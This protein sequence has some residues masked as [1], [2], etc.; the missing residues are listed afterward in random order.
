MTQDIL[1]QVMKLSREVGA[2]LLE[3]TVSDAQ[4][5]AKSMNNL[6]SFVDQ[7][8]ERMFVE[9]LQ[10]ILPEAGFI[11]EEGSASHND[12][13]YLWVIDPLDG[14]T[15]YIHGIP[16][17]CTSVGLLKNRKSIMGVI[18][19][20]CRDEM[21][22]ALLGKGAFLN[23]KP[24]Q[25]SHRNSLKSSVLATGFP[26]DDFDRQDQYMELFGDLCK[27]S[28]G[29]RRWGSA[30]IDMAWVAVGRFEGFYEYGLN[31]WDIAAGVIIVEEAG[32]QVDAFTPSHD[33][34]FD[35]EIVATNGL[36]QQELLAKVGEYF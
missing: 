21:F 11:A 16:A 35:R 34:I 19:D 15:N 13:E 27:S 24:I 20:P 25:V 9:G 6:V 8:A 23:G 31:P 28:R 18:Y 14:T 5:E 10:E 30:A 33:A 2:F 1:E 4:I 36:I 12:E 26:Y 22:S 32:G 3:Q 7:T 17:F 29:L